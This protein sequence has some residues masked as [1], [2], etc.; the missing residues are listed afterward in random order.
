MDSC[1]KPYVRPDVWVSRCH[2]RIGSTAGTV[3]GLSTEPLSYTRR[4][5][6]AGS[7]RLIS[8][9]SSKWPSSQSIIAATEVTGLVIE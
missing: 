5:A 9:V 7:H 8:S 1:R 2:M 6:N 4:S 3:N